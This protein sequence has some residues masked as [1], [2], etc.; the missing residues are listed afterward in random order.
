MTEMIQQM[1]RMM[2]SEQMMDASSGASGSSDVPISGTKGGVRTL[3]GAAVPSITNIFKGE[4][5]RLG[6][7]DSSC[8]E[9]EGAGV[10]PPQLREVDPE[11]PLI[12]LRVTLLDRKPANVTVNRDFTLED[13]RAWLQHHQ[14]P[15]SASNFNLMDVTGFPPRKLADLGAT[16]GDLGLTKDSTL[17]CRPA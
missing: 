5:C 13:L 3:N 10:T 11:K 4:G 8:H 16:I 14:G 12:R 15:T 7:T 1:K 2:E 17:A 6:S 9:S